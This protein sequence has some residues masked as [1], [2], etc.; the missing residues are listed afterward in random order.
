MKKNTSIVLFASVFAIAVGALGSGVAY[1]DAL[2]LPQTQEKIDMVGTVEY[3]VLDSSGNIKQYMQ[4]DNIVVND[5]KD[6]AADAIFGGGTCVG[7]I[8]TNYFDY[9]GI[10]NGSRTALSATDSTLSDGTVDTTGTCAAT[11]IG[12]DMARKQVTPIHTAASGS[13]G[14]VV[15]LDTSTSP[16]TFDANNATTIT[17]AGIFNADYGTPATDNKCGGQNI[18]GTDWDMFARQFLG[19]SGIT[20]DD[21]DS[22]SVK[23]TITFG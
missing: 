20:V 18:A 9:I 8:G 19:D 13:T 2:T 15:V 16:F 17:D 4:I 22:L 6:C 11:N 7:T 12:G 23:W 10:G 21:G 14:A 5:G 3:T 1:P